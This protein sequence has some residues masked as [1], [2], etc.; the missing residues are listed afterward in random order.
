VSPK[1]SKRYTPNFCFF[2]YV[3][4]LFWK[5]SCKTKVK[6]HLSRFWTVIEKFEANL[7]DSLNF[8]FGE[9]HFLRQNKSQTQ[10]LTFVTFMNVL[11]FWLIF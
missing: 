10:K 2:L 1:Q 8:F 11:I 5:N 9:V 6:D 4:L 7:A 3:F